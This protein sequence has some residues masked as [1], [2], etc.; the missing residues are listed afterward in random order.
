MPATPPTTLYLNPGDGGAGSGKAAKQR[1]KGA[2]QPA[3]R[4]LHRP[5]S[6]YKPSNPL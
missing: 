4:V 2:S 5:G 3:F 6:E 1:K